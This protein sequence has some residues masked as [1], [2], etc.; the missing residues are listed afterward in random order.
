MLDIA[1][2]LEANEKVISAENE[3]DVAAAQQAGYEKSL[4][5]RL[6]LKPGKVC[7]IDYV[8]IF[9]FSFYYLPFGSCSTFLISKQILPLVDA[10]LIGSCTVSQSWCHSLTSCF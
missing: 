6:V 3:A 5:S 7:C 2:A 8:H 4:I 1:D 9:D 10:I